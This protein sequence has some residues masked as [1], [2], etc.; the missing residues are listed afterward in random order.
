M[1]NTS[2]FNF[3]G[4]AP[5]FAAQIIALLGQGLST[6]ALALFAYD[7]EGGN[8]G[9]LLGQV[10]VVKMVAYVTI[11]PIAGSFANHFPR[12]RLLVS[13]DVVRALCVGAMFFVDSVWQIYV[14]MF[15]LSACSA[16]FKPVF[17]ATIPD[18]VVNETAY[19]KALAYSRV[20]YDL[21][22]LL[23]PLMAGL[24]LLVFTFSDLFLLNALAF[25]V[26]GLLIVTTRLKLPVTAPEAQSWQEVS[27]GIVSY[28][29]TPRLRGVLFLFLPIAGVSA[30]MIINSVVY[31]KS[32]LGLDDEM[33][34]L[35]LAVSGIGSMAVALAVPKL[36]EF[37]R[38]R[39]IM[40]AGVI[41]G[42]LATACL[43]FAPDFLQFCV[44][45]GFVG[46]GLS[47]AQTPVGSVITQSSNAVDR[48]AYFSAQFSLS[49]L[50]W[51][52][53]YP[54]VG[55]L[56]AEFTVPVAGLMIALIGAVFLLVAIFTWP[57]HERFSL[58]HEHEELHHQHKMANDE[59]HPAIE[60]EDGR[61]H[62][63]PAKVHE[64]HFVIDRHH[65][66]WP[67]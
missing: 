1:K 46:A 23:S 57:A 20:A 30:M 27:F 7:L 60:D 35:A 24:A 55:Y 22:S 44:I 26:S 54:L 40:L 32:D 17:Q 21:E 63:H 25:A 61:G 8:A 15:A 49:H 53:A 29:R 39:T 13:L 47:L 51:M 9:V 11:A 58:R 38:A 34:A 14:L 62:V 56:G 66:H 52:F 10:L 64:H 37:M 48:P 18:I 50:C 16:S 36:L 19:N 2:P 59:L 5:L 3:S 65:R 4:F 12:K 31:V 45:L 33:L 67:E 28:L 43:W 42:L 6:V 41:V